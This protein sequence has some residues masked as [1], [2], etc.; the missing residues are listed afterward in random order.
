MRLGAIDFISKPYDSPRFAATVRNALERERLTSK[1]DGSVNAHQVRQ[2]LDT[3]IGSSPSMSR[4]K[5]LVRK[6]VSANV[7][8]LLS[9]ESGTG[10][11]VLARAIHAESHR[12]QNPFLA[13][14]CGAIPENLIESELFGHAKGAFTG[15]SK[16]RAGLFEQAHGGSLFLDEIGELRIDLQVKLLRVLQDRCVRRLGCE[17]ERSLDVRVIA[18]T[19]LQLQEEVTAGRFRNDLYYRLSVFPVELPSL[20]ERNRDILELA[21]Y[22]LKKHGDR[23]GT[24]ASGFT[25]AAERALLSYHW[26][27]NVRELENAVERS[28]LLSETDQ[29]DLPNLPGRLGG[30]TLGAWPSGYGDP[31]ETPF[32]GIEPPVIATF[33]AEEQRILT[34]A[35]EI[36]GG[37][38]KEAARRLAIGRATV[39]RKIRA[40]GIVPRSEKRA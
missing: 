9:G 17:K 14:N 20:R 27:G 7:T 32:S 31:L 10:K 25:P 34:R 38:V 19:N 29:V 35:L 13:I 5:E 21:H 12:A 33:A 1:V 24:Q 28:M 18:A 11:E 16:S 22:F 8:V 2:G 40:Y 37:N 26:P 6:V 3:L 4:T 36:T 30:Q 15:A 23:L 39:Y